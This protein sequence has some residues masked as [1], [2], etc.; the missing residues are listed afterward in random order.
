MKKNLIL[1]AALVPLL[2]YNVVTIAAGANRAG[3][4]SFTL[5]AGYDFF[6]LKRHIQN[7][8][9]AYGALGYSFTDQWGVEAFLGFY[10]TRF[11]NAI[12]DDRQING[13]NFALDGVYHF[14]VRDNWIQPFGLFGIGIIGMKPNGTS[15][16]NEANINAGFGLQFFANQAVAV[17]TE[18]RDFYTMVGGKNDVM[19]D[20]GVTFFLDLC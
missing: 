8:G 19:L 6:A 16:H 17:R 14:A 4:L 10:N 9:I 1:L 18:F 13:T 11:K 2:S 20:A 3:A 7:T 5:G 12:S 15:A